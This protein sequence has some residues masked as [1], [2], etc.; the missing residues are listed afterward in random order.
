MSFRGR[1]DSTEATPLLQDSL[2]E[3]Q[4]QKLW[5]PNPK[6]RGIVWG[7]LTLTFLIALVLVLG[8]NN[9]FG[10]V[11]RPWLGFLPKDPL[12][13]A[14]IILRNAPVIVRLCTY[15]V[16]LCLINESSRTVIL[17]GGHAQC[18]YDMPIPS[19]RFTVS[20]AIAILQQC[21]CRRSGF[22]HTRA[23]RHSKVN[24]RKS[25][26]VLLARRHTVSVL[27]SSFSL[28]LHTFLAQSLMG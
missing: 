4:Q 22:P 5:P 13:A 18:V 20:R 11:V 25:G 3:E 12:L 7:S 28:G 2:D 26:R 24:K 17:V 21:D 23:C 27:P 1:R 9:E 19:H 6:S 8:F 16:H 10:D 14:Q 15:S